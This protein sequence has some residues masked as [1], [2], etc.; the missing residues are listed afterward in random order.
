MG[1]VIRS[2]VRAEPP[3]QPLTFSTAQAN[4]ATAALRVFAGGVERAFLTVGSKTVT[5]TGQSRTFTDKKRIGAYYREDF[6]RTVSNG[7]G[8]S[9]HY[10]SWSIANVAASAFSVTGTVGRIVTVTDNTSHY[11][12]LNDEITAPDVKIRFRVGTLTNSGGPCQF[13]IVMNYADTSNH[14]RARV[15]VKSTGSYDLIISKF[16]GSNETVLA[17]VTNVLTGLAINTWLQLRF[18]RVGNALSASLWLDSGSEPVAATAT[19]A[20]DTQF[21]SGKV[22]IRAFDGE[23]A[24]HMT[25]EV[26]WLDVLNGSWPV[27]PSITHSTWVRTLTAPYTVWNSTV[28]TQVRA[29]IADTSPDLL[30]QAVNYI[31]DSLF[32]YDSRYYNTGEAAVAKAVL[33]E[34]SYGALQS[35]GT[36]AEGADFNDFIRIPWQ[37][38]S[39]STPSTDN[40]ETAEQYMLDSSGFVRMIYGFWG[41]L[42]MSLS[43]SADLNGLNLPRL[44]TQVGPSG[45]GVLIATGS[46]SAPTLTNIRIG[47]VIR[48][49]STAAASLAGDNASDVETG[50]DHLGIYL[51]LD[52]N[53]NRVFI[54]SR[55]I[56]NGPGFGPIGG[57]PYLN[58]SGYWALAVRDVRRF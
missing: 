41:G 21:T 38:P 55:K 51:G 58:G 28:E 26:D 37:Y 39:L 46:S 33:G 44:G 15:V 52:Q 2:E 54:S 6:T 4:P 23:G 8:T 7:W 29:M 17:T 10:G 1:I 19:V 32:V 48:F 14:Y 9:P 36:R 3:I 16:V 27:T 12:V 31:N 56:T 34:A 22:G 47:D 13:G 24:P 43:A 20:S 5:V 42:P 40:P 30:S 57:V 35:N 49:S 18:W 53:D 45:P 11:V 25:Y 50:D